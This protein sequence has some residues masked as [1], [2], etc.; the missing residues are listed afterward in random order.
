[1]DL[2]RESEGERQDTQ[3]GTKLKYYCIFIS[4][5]T[6]QKH[7]ILGCDTLKVLLWFTGIWFCMIFNKGPA[8]PL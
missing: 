1:M 7:R 6:Y 4:I 2:G 5:G 8:S 3:I